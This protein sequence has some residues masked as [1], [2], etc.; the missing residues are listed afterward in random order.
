MRRSHLRIVVQALEEQAAQQLVSYWADGKSRAQG[1]L[2]LGTSDKVGKGRIYNSTSEP[3][4][5]KCAFTS[6][7]GSDGYD[8]IQKHNL[9]S[10][11]GTKTHTS[12]SSAYKDSTPCALWPCAF[13]ARIRQRRFAVAWRLPAQQQEHS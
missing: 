4:S 11:A 5:R 8:V 3:F 9:N 6:R 13:C 10:R 12:L 7:R 1:D 2:C